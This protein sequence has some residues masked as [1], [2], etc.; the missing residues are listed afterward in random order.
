[1]SASREYER[2]F[3]ISGLKY[4]GLPQIVVLL[5]VGIF[6]VFWLEKVPKS[7][8]VILMKFIQIKIFSN[9]RSLC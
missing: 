2:S 1:M 7:K 6:V 9:F 8:S 3:N 5:T 4:K